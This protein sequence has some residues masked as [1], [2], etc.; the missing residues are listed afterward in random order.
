LFR[1]D[2]HVRAQPFEERRR[3][4]P[5]MSR[6]STSLGAAVNKDLDGRK[7]PAMTHVG[8]CRNATCSRFVVEH[9]LLGKPVFAH[10]VKPEGMLVRIML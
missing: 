8:C 10:R 7:S 4:A 5:P 3:F 1:R 6:A 9:G 2:R